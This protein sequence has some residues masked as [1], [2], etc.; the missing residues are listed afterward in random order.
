MT[1]LLFDMDGVLV[2]VS[3]SYRLAIQKTVLAFS[4]R[5]PAPQLIQSYKNRGGFN[6]DWDLTQAILT[7]FGSTPSR[8]EIIRIFQGHYCGKKFDGLINKENWLLK[9]EILQSLQGKYPLGIVTG[10]PGDEARHTLE[11]FGVTLYFQTCICLEDVGLEKGKPNPKGILMAL[12]DLKT[13]KGFYAGDTRDDM[14]AASRAGIGS[15][16]IV[17]EGE[18]TAG[19]DILRKSGAQAVIADIN[20]IEEVI[21]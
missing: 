18:N 3:R 9:R 1:A 7:D 12:A 19:A 14:E 20:L 10:R 13:N 15:I 6:N 17:P 8:E 4:G 5:N 11:R 21:Q 2:D 16:G